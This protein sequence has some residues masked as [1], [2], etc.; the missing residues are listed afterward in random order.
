M[1]KSQSRPANPL[2]HFEPESPDRIDKDIQATPTDQKRGVPDPGK[3]NFVR[4]QAWELRSMRDTFATR[5]KRRKVNF[6]NKVP[7]QPTFARFETDTMTIIPG[8]LGILF[9]RSHLIPILTV[10][11]QASLDRRQS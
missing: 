4:T 9:A 6:R 5:K 3:T 1:M 2:N 7:T 8:R 10:F 11:E